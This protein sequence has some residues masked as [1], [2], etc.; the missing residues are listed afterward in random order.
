M[1]VRKLSAKLKIVR[2]HFPILAILGPRQSGKTTLVKT[3]FD[4]LPY[5]TLEDRD[6]QRFAIEDPRGF[7]NNLKEGAVIDEAQNV[8]DLFSFL[9]THVDA[10]QKK[11]RFILT[12]SQN[13]LMHSKI[14][15]SLAG[16]VV[17]STLLPLS[18]EEIG[19]RNSKD[20]LSCVLQG[21]Y[22]ALQT[23]P[24]ET[25]TAWFNSYVQTYIERDV[26]SLKN[27]GDLSKFRLFL[28]LCA[29]R[30]GQILNVSSLAQDAG[31]ARQTATQW[32]SLLEASFVIF[33]LKPYHTNYNKRLIKNPKLYFF[34][35]GIVNYLI[36]IRQK[37]Q[38]LKSYL[39]GSII[40]NWV[41]SEL[42]KAHT[43]RLIPQKLYFWRDR[44]G[45]EVDCL[46]ETGTTVRAIEVKSSE[47]IQREYYKGI[48]YWQ[49]ISGHQDAFLIY[50]GTRQ[51]DR[52]NVT[53]I[54][55]QAL[56]T[57]DLIETLLQ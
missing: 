3:L 6:T 40:E 26:H 48:G 13:F 5:V 38:L 23:M 44:T 54:G 25:F 43:N 4:D 56:A 19:E 20:L 55:W 35:T 33:L 10:L 41:M 53:A 27:I 52:H 11:G 24:E 22:P 57:E 50:G 9:Q 39:K 42:Y 15:Q 18:L 8:P 36:G 31:I 2:P 32:L 1:I 46:L 30:V 37:E 49:K 51:E 12:G 21:G 28:E 34:D 17:L 29:N 16:R 7:L 14:S 47:T 45:H